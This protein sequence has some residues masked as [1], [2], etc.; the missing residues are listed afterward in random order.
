MKQEDQ[1]IEKVKVVV[2]IVTIMVTQRRSELSKN[3][4]I[5]RKVHTIY[6]INL[7]PAYTHLCIEFE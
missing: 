3:E 5:D 2:V 7:K 4:G 6:L 1:T